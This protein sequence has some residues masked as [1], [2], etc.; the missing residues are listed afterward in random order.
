MDDSVR[1]HLFQTSLNGSA[2]KWYIKLDET[3]F[4]FFNNLEMAFLTHYQLAIWYDIGMDLLTSLSEDT[5]TH[6]YDHIHEWR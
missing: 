3:Y 6:I 1:L 5:T 2:K 4:N